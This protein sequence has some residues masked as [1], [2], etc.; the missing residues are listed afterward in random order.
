MEDSKKIDFLDEISNYIFVSKYSRYVDELNRRETWDEAVDRLLSMHLKK[1]SFLNKEDKNKIKWAF[2]LV[3]QKRIV[4][5][6]RSLQFGGKAIE[7]HNPRIYNCCVR[8]IDSLRSFAEMFYLLLCGTGTGL[9]LSK[10]FLNR[11]PDL[12]NAVDKTGTIVSYVVEDTIQGWAD[13][14]EALLDCYFRNTP[15]TG[16]KIVFDY[17]KIRKKGERLKTGGGKAP[18]YKGL[19]NAHI[20]IKELLDNVIENRNQSRLKSIDAYDI[21][22]HCAD[23]VLSGGIRRS[24][25]CVVFDKDDQ[26]MLN[27]KTLQKIDKA[28][29]FEEV[30]EEVSGGYT[31][32]ILEGKVLKDGVKYELTIKDW[33]LDSIKKGLVNWWHLHPQRGRSNNSV[34]LL[35]ESTTLDEFKSIVE[36]TKQFGEPGFVFADHPWTLFNPCFEISFIPVTDD[37]VCGVQFCNLCSMNGRLTDTVDKFKENVEAYTIIGTLQAGYTDFPYLNKA[38]ETLTRDE[39]LLGLS[40]TGMMDNPDI[41]LNPKTQKEMAKYSVEVNKEWADKL[42]VKQAARITCIKPEGCVRKDSMVITSEG[43]LT[44]EEIGDIHGEEWQELNFKVTTDKKDQVVS[45]FYING[46]KPTKLIKTSG[47]LEIECTFNHKFRVIRDGSYIWVESKDITIGDV[48]PSK[49]GGYNGG[50][51]QDLTSNTLD[52][53]P[54]ATRIN[55]DISLPSKLDKDFAWFLGLYTGDGSNHPSKYSIRVHGDFRHQENLLRAK[56]YLKNSFN[57]DSKVVKYNKDTEDNRCALYVTSRVFYEF[58]K[59]NDLL[60][61]RSENIEIPL[62]IRKSKKEVLSSFIDGYAAADGSTKTNGRSFCTTSKVM[63]NQLT[64]CLRAIGIESKLRLMPPTESSFGSLMRYWISQRKGRNGNISKSKYFKHYKMLDSLGMKDFTVDTVVSVQD[65]VCDTYDLSVEHEDHT[66]IVNSYVS[67]N[68]SSLVLGTGSGIHPHHAKKYFRR[69]INNKIDNVYKFFKKHNPH[70]CQT[71]VWSANK[72]DD[73]I[74][75]PIKVNDCAR[76]KGD[77]NAIEHLKI[78]KSTQQNW[79]ITGTTEANKKPINHNVSCTVVVKPEE[80]EGVIDFIFENRKYF[81][82]V[83]LLSSSGDKDYPQAPM[84]AVITEEDEA[85][86]QEIVSKM[87]HVDYT[88]LKEDDDKTAL[89]AE[90]SCAGGQCEINI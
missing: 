47:G 21:L 61:N 17:S 20:K 29:S 39:S 75:F 27:A 36:R 51:D 57:L 19:K 62:I 69:V 24:A 26:D 74:T 4:P 7:S 35:R 68:T 52:L 67:H 5:S 10:F 3:K 83:S 58:L 43:L 1:Y 50:S 70:M 49:I 76:V 79:V 80:W 54:H 18:G 6:M 87:K 84:E 46:R 38:S 42:N 8:H 44:M 41:L 53:S 11:L 73:V 33:E 88:Q 25:T 60:K 30:G 85:K 14:M 89:Q 78:I 63:A 28:Y 34:L 90:F 66:Y 15:Y 2:D 59:T 86:W 45:K 37:G 22:M 72:T 81:T 9:G 56:E 31:T 64:N 65:S 48:L 40:I 13:S 71:S 23:A 77:L 55:L 32:K 82:A 16:R 12:V